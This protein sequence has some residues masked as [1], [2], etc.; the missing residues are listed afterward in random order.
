MHDAIYN[1]TAASEKLARRFI[2]ELFLNSENTVCRPV[3]AEFCCLCCCLWWMPLLPIMTVTKL[4]LRHFTL[5]LR[6]AGFRISRHDFCRWVASSKGSNVP[7]SFPE[8]QAH[9]K[10]WSETCANRPA[11]KAKNASR[12]KVSCK[13]HTRGEHQEGLTCR[14]KNLDLVAGGGFEP[15]TFGL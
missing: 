13:F 14:I 12:G 4:L 3:F 7:K 11:T 10:H 15:P 1:M 2:L 8:I 9:S 5:G 6:K